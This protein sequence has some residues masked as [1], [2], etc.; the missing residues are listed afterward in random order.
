MKLIRYI[1]IAGILNLFLLVSNITL[2]NSCSS[3]NHSDV[4]QRLDSI[5]REDI[6][7][8]NL[9][10]MKLLALYG[11]GLRDTYNKT[12]ELD[13]LFQSIHYLIDKNDHKINLY[14]GQISELLREDLADFMVLSNLETFTQWDFN[15]FSKGELRIFIYE[16]QQKLLSFLFS[17]IFK[18]DFKISNIEARVT[19]E[20][21][22]IK[23][24]EDFN[25]EIELIVS[26]V[27]L[28]AFIYFNNEQI[29][30]INGVGKLKIETNEIG[31][32]EKQGKVYILNPNIGFV[33]LPF[34]IEFKVY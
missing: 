4:K 11:E 23:S 34:D 7:N 25:A 9:D 1:R 26:D 19:S 31:V 27:N 10:F 6:Y 8:A 30:F 24:G 21:E 28:V 15:E 17:S 32:F 22:R 13:E 18:D 33:E 16:L 3:N 2:L 5:Y 29:D 12:I 20:K 14:L